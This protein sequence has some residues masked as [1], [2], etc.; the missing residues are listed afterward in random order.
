MFD[1]IEKR[2]MIRSE[3]TS[4]V[5][6]RNHNKTI[7]RVAEADLPTKWG[8][9]R[10]MVI[11]RENTCIFCVKTLSFYERRFFYNC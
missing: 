4:I 1:S 10:Q 8:K 5:P 6:E 9:F 7:E 11:L 3:Q 2:E